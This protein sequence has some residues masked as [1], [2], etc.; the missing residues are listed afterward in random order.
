MNLNC[1]ALVLSTTWSVEPR[2]RKLRALHSNGCL[3]S[4]LLTTCLYATMLFPPWKSWRNCQITEERLEHWWNDNYKE[5]NETLEQEPA[6]LPLG[7]QVPHEPLW[8]CT[9][10]LEV[11]SQASSC[12]RSF[13][14]P[15]NLMQASK[16]IFLRLLILKTCSV[17]KYE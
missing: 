6:P 8:D 7:P 5:I 11:R 10:A 9:L 16:C 3:Q 17:W 13:N 2:T 14:L 12:G 15:D 1:T 4:H